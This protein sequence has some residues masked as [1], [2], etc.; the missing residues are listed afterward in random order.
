MVEKSRLKSISDHFSIEGTCIGASPFG[1]GLVHESFEA[2]C[3]VEDNFHRYLLQK[4]N[5]YVFQNPEEV[6]ENI[7]KVLEH[8][9]AIMIKEGISEDR[10]RQCLRLVKSEKGLSYYRDDEGGYW[11]VYD[12]IEHTTVFNHAENESQAY[13]AARMFGRFSRYLADLDPSQFNVTIPDFHN[14]DWRYNQL[15][16]ALKKDRLNRRKNC[17]E[18]INFLMRKRGI[19]EIIL[20]LMKENELP[21]R[22]THNDTKINN[23]LIDKMTH[24]GLCVV[25]LDTIM[26]GTI[27]SDFGDMMRTFTPSLNEESKE[28]DKI[29]LRLPIF[30]A[31]VK[32][33]LEETGSFLTQTEKDHL[34][35]GG[36][37]ITLMQGIRFLTDYLNG[38]IYYRTTY[39]E[40]NLMRTRNQLKLMQEMIYNE[41]KMEAILDK[42]SG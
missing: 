38:D 22:V 27:L 15:E 33:F 1:S 17:Q 12:F 7:E 37:L 6:M 36:K 41:S 23:V 4:I 29:Y 34:I 3:K 42:Y 8:I 25:D 20:R 13:E 39:P 14:I 32:G 11:R 21:V 16:E 24:K 18:E 31:L 2:L 9:N 28:I 35:Y 5:T 10:E 26:P 40:Q 30:Q 19:S